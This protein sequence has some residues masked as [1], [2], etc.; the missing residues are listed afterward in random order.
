M[1]ELERVKQKY[2]EYIGY[3]EK[4]LRKY[5]ETKEEIFKI[6]FELN[7]MQAGVYIEFCGI[8]P[9]SRYLEM[10]VELETLK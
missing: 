6:G 4:W 7:M 1:N 9:D 3:A 5:K 10:K 2:E 8:E